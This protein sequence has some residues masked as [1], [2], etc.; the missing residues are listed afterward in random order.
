M[1]GVIGDPGNEKY[2]FWA[3]RN[4]IELFQLSMMRDDHDSTWLGTS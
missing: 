3:S 1:Q 4:K 2:E